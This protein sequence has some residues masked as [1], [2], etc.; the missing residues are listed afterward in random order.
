MVPHVARKRPQEHR[1]QSI[2]STRDSTRAGAMRARAAPLLRG[3]G[4]YS[5]A[6]GSANFHTGSSLNNVTNDIDL[7]DT[8]GMDLHKFTGGGLVGFNFG[9]GQRFHLDFTYWGYYDYKGDKDV[10]LIVFGD[11]VFTGRVISRVRLHE[12]DV[13]FRFDFWKPDAIDLTF[14]GTLG[15]RLFYIDAEAHESASATNDS[16]TFL[17]PIP[18][19][20][21]Q[22]RWGITPNVYVQGGVAGFYAGDLASY[23]ELTAEAGVDLTKN[24]G[25]FVGYRYWTFNLEFDDDS[26][27]VDNSMV[28][29]GVEVRL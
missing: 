2:C 22:L 4:I 14:T 11:N 23:L 28:Y 5:E 16:V 20:G 24:V 6:T 19:P 21:L 27:E 13:D 7:E 12:A 15:A 26:Y 25:V 10:G 29:A 17:A 1:S 8:L 9:P 3:F 18:A